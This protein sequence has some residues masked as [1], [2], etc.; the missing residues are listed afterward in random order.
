[1]EAPRFSVPVPVDAHIQRGIVGVFSQIPAVN[2]PRM[3]LERI[4]PFT[5]GIMRNSIALCRGIQCEKTADAVILA[6]QKT[7][8]VG[9]GGLAPVQRDLR[10][11][12]AS[13][14]ARQI[15]SHTDGPRGLQKDAAPP[16]LGLQL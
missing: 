9:Q 1:N 16:G 2:L 3:G 10:R 12:Q 5:G 8:E 14:R 6:M 11:L 15:S 13:R 7:K 4:G